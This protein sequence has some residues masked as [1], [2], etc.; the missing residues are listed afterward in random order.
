MATLQGLLYLLSCLTSQ[1]LDIL[2]VVGRIE[3]HPAILPSLA[4]PLLILVLQ[5]LKRLAW[6]SLSFSLRL[7]CW[8]L[9]TSFEGKFVRFCCLV[10]VEG[11]NRQSRLAVICQHVLAVIF[12]KLLVIKWIGILRTVAETL[13]QLAIWANKVT[14]HVVKVKLWPR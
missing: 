5:L 10:V 14:T 12:V 11:A 3:T 7:S 4:P 6:N 9:L 2:H 8:G 1:S 13:K